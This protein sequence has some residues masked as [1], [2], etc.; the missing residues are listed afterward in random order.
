MNRDEALSLLTKHLKN[1]NL[2][3]HCLAVEACMRALAVRLG[4]DPEPWGLAGIL[5]DLDYEVTEKSPD[6]HT[7]ETVKILKDAGVAE[8]VIYAVQA[9]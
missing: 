3:K 4:H 7:T 2:V 8:P 1:R 9:H 5:H 6:L